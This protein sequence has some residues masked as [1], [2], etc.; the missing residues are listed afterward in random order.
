MATISV[1]D[2]SGA[3]VAMKTTEASSVHTSHVIVDKIFGSELS[4]SG[5][6]TSANQDVSNTWLDGIYDLVSGQAQGVISFGLSSVAQTSSQTLYYLNGTTGVAPAAQN[7]KVISDVPDSGKSWIIDAVYFND[8][9]TLAAGDVIIVKLVV[10]ND[11]TT[12]TAQ[13]GVVAA[14][15]F[16]VTAPSEYYNRI[17][18]LNPSN[19]LKLFPGKRLLLEVTKSTAAASVTLSFNGSIWFRQITN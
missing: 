9:T 17:F 11:N 4:G 14:F 19:G 6:A 3:T 10:T 2:A 1:K 5:V 7:P 18:E 15:S 12:S 8:Q 16:K 13:S